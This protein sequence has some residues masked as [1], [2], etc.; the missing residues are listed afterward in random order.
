M[1]VCCVETREAD[2][3]RKVMSVPDPDW[4]RLERLGALAAVMRELTAHD[5]SD[6]YLVSQEQL[7]ELFG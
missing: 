4:R 5:T 3:W 6:L 1:R 7:G 2:K